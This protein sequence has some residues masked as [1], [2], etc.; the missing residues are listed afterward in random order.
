MINCNLDVFFFPGAERQKD[1]MFFFR[2]KTNIDHIP[3]TLFWGYYYTSYIDT[4]N[5]YYTTC[6]INK[7]YTSQ[8]QK[9]TPLIWP[10][11][12][13]QKSLKVIMH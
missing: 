7:S 8:L 3:A 13:R 12:N 1:K 9:S 6:T 2:T 11:H 4:Q 10:K 5:S